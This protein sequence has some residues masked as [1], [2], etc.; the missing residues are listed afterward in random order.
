MPSTNRNGII[1]LREITALGVVYLL[2]RAVHAHSQHLEQNVS[3]VRNVVHPRS[4][5][6]ARSE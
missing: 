2:V 4:D 1:A 5:R 3:F 6:S